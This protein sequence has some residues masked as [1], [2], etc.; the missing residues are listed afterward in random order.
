MIKVLFIIRD[1]NAHERRTNELTS[2]PAEAAETR[3]EKGI[4]IA[5][6]LIA[7]IVKN[8]SAY[9]RQGMLADI[10]AVS[11]GVGGPVPNTGIGLAKIDRTLRINA[12]G[13]LGKDAYGDFILKT[14]KENGISTDLIKISDDNPTSFTDV[15]SQPDGERTFFHMRGANAEFSPEDV[16]MAELAR[17]TKLL[18][19]GY[20]ML[21]DRF[22]AED[23]EY[24]TVM[25]RFL[26]DV[27]QAGI[28]TSID[29][30]SSD[31]GDFP[32]T[33]IPALKYCDYV[34]INEIEACL[35]WDV[36]PYIDS[37]GRSELNIDG[38]RSAM[39][40]MID[41]GVNEKVIVHAKSAGMCLS[42]DVPNAPSGGGTLPADNDIRRFTVVPSL[43]IPGELIKGSVG[44]GDA[45]CAGA[46]YG[47]YTGMS[48]REML[49]F[50]S[51][52][53]ATCLF[54]ANSTDGIKNKDEI[55]EIINKFE[56]K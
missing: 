56:R 23:S 18:H 49:R 44:A 19:T 53:A 15:M 33:V 5:G 39:E 20:V 32:R 11:A 50:A 54:S 27:Q 22:D 12:L 30:V 35:I 29:V 8:I 16:D 45:F 47:I 52:A 13:R 31:S 17:R 2:K 25:A 51:G 43:N 55:Y 48:D 40:R 36:E 28:K 14:L 6:N 4:A 1:E 42:R 9:P 7:D 34:I 41:A 46:L 24:G 38:I 21:L 3:Q 10:T 37:D 26:R